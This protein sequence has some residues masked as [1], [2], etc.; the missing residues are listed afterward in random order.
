MEAKV[1]DLK[2]RLQNPRSQHCR[3]RLLYWDQSTYMPPGGASAR[4]R[5][6]RAGAADARKFTD[7]VGRLLDDLQPYE[8]SL[9]YEHDDA[10]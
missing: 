6:L 5:Q 3:R 10:G 1:A 4:A 9:P 2:N 8:E 7:P